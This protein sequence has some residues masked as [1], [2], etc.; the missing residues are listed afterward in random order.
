MA[1]DAADHVV[2]QANGDVQSVELNELRSGTR[3][4]DKQY[5]DDVAGR[6]LDAAL[7]HEARAEEV[8]AAERMGVLAKV[9]RSQCVEQSGTLSEGICWDGTNTWDDD[10]PRVRCRLVAQELK[11]N[12]SNFE[13]FVA[14]PP[15]A[16]VTYMASRVA[17]AQH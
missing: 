7:V 17:S 13:L 16:Y 12:D 4:C 6:V 2:L 3:D 10:N 14:T 15:I 1:L 11:R 8:R 5:L 9:L